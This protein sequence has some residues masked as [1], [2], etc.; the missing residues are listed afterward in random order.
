LQDPYFLGTSYKYGRYLNHLCY[1]YG[2]NGFILWTDKGLGAEKVPFL[3]YVAGGIGMLIGGWL[4]YK[5]Y[6]PFV[7]AA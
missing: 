3:P 4:L 6:R 7:S 1:I 5:P 2:G